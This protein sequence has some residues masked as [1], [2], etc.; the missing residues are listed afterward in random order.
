MWVWVKIAIVL[1]V[2]MLAVAYISLAERKLLAFMQIRIGPNRVGW[3]GIL[4]PIVDGIKLLTKECIV[5][6]HADKWLYRM[7]PVVSIAFSL[8][9]FAVV[10]FA[11]AFYITDINIA[12]LLVLAIGSL[13]FIGTIM[14]GWS[15]SSKYPFLG[16]LRALALM[17]SFE[18]PMVIVMVGVIMFCRSLSMVSIVEAQAEWGWFIHLQPVAFVIYL[19]CG[20]AETQRIPF[21]MLE[22]EG[23]L[24]T[25]FFTEYSG[26]RFGLFFMA[27]YANMFMV[28]IM[29]TVLFLGGWQR[30][31]ASWAWFNFLDVVPSVFWFSAKVLLFMF[32]YIWLRGS[33][34]RVRYDQLMYLCWKILLPLAMLNLLLTAVYLLC[35][36]NIL[37]F[38]LLN[39]LMVVAW[40]KIYDIAQAQG[41]A[42]SQ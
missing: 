32:L 3:H 6:A 8:V 27:E 36:M 38:Y 2:L 25:G 31:F 5:P 16:S 19:L 29:A 40:L 13:G 11:R 10:P 22:D 28:S 21:D 24:V 34:P 26:M 1:S 18:V 4:Q 12:L 15:S 7:A 9:P 39:L 23:S 20:I 42:V 35:E 33:L 41:T 30:P 37:L 17:I 14:A